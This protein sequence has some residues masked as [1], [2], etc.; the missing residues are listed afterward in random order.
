VQLLSDGNGI[1]VSGTGTGNI[2]RYNYVHDNVAH[3]LPAAIRCDDDQHETLIYGNVLYNNRGFSAGI[4][5]KGINDIINNFI[6]DPAVVPRSGYI[7]FEWVPVTDSK[8]H[9]NV[10]FSHPDGGKAHNERYRGRDNGGRPRPKLVDTD[11][12]N[13]LYY[14]PTDPLWVDQHLH[15]MR[16]V[17][18]EKAS[19]FGDPLFVDPAGGDFSFR[20]DSPALA[21][22]IEP[23]DVS[24]M[25][26]RDMGAK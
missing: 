24:K 17:G 3:S 9:R 15:K 26:R 6:V 2:V 21:L 11:M 10:I 13:N 20:P 23:L 14:H 1:Y 19:R 8:V 4:A 22:G 25:G 5:S 18:K 16:A 12:D 7:S